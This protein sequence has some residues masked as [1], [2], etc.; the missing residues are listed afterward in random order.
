MIRDRLVVGIRDIT[1]S[2]QLQTNAELTLDKAKKKSYANVKL[3]ISNSVFSKEEG[4]RAS[5]L[6]NMAATEAI[7]DRAKPNQKGHP[8]PERSA[9]VVVST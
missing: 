2:E 6:Y 8:L 7:G 3:S 4:H 9:H 1:L 5:R